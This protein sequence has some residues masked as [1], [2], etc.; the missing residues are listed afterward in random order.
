MDGG[1]ITVVELELQLQLLFQLNHS[2]VTTIS[3]GQPL[4]WM[5]P[6]ISQSNAYMIYQ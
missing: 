2:D 4:K 1:H 3:S 5:L 6:Y